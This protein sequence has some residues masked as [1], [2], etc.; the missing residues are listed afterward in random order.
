[1]NLER[2]LDVSWKERSMDTPSADIALDD[3]VVSRLVAEQRPDLAGLPLRLVQNGWDNALYRLGDTLAV[4]LPRRRVAAQLIEGE[5]RW[6]PEFAKRLDVAIPA[7]IHAGRPT[8][9]YPYHWS[10]VPWFEGTAVTE[11]APA[12]RGV[13]AHDLA[14]FLEQLHAPAPTG[15]H[16]HLRHDVPRNPV[17][18]G[19]L[20]GRSDAVAGRLAS[21]TIPRAPEVAAVWR[22]AVAA[23]GWAGPPLWLHGDLHP[24]NIIAGPDGVVAVIDFGDLT[25]GDPAT[26]L[27]TAWLTFDA[28]ARASFR[29]AVEA[30][31][32]YDD[33]TWRRARGWAVSLGTAMAAHSDDNPRMASAGAHVLEQ[34]LTD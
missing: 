14:R 7:P 3:A 16:S 5:Q 20:A 13:I 34:L 25:A 17:R 22:D 1:M 4:R 10:I 27:A 12:R 26:D 15:E 11:L 18:G 29:A 24:A 32:R 23:P 2:L 21:G 30:G 9:D 31:H 19:A 8:S 6:L 28:P 33:D